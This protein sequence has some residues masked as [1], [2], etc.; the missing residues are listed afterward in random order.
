MTVDGA[1]LSDRWPSAG[2]VESSLRGFTPDLMEFDSW[3]ASLDNLKFVRRLG[4]DGSGSPVSFVKSLNNVNVAV[5][6]ALE[7]EIPC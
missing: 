3:Y 5:L 6:G 2:G 1:V 7:E 4:W